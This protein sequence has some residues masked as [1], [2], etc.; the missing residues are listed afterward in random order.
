MKKDIIGSIYQDLKIY[1]CISI[2]LFVISCSKSKDVNKNLP[3]IIYIL[4]DDLGYGELGVYGQ[5]KIETPHIDALA[6]SGMK[7]TEHYAGSAV[8]APSRYMLMKGKHPGNAY[9]RGNDELSE[10]GDIWS[11]EAMYDNPELE[12]QRPIPAETVTIGKLLQSA[13]YKTGAIGKW[14]LGGPCTVGHPNEQGF[15][16]FYGYLCQRQAHTYY[17]THLWKNKQ[18]VYLDNELISPHQTLSEELDPYEWSS[19]EKFQDQPDHSAEL[20]HIEALQFIEQNQ[21]NK[22]FLYLPTPI[23]H[24]PLQAP[25]HWID[26]YVNKFGDEEP[27]PG[28]NYTPVRY[29]NATYAALISYMDEQVGELIEKLKDLD[30]YDNTLIIFTSDNGPTFTG[31]VD[32]EYFDSAAPFKGTYGWGKGYLHE[33]GIRVPMIASWNGKIPEGS[34][35]DHISAQ[36]DVLPTLSEIAGIETP[37]DIDG[38]SFLPTLIG[39]EKEQKQHEFLYWEIPEYG[40]Q[41][42][43]RMGKWK[44][45][46]KNMINNQNI[47]IELFDLEKDIRED[48][49]IADEHPDIVEKIKLIME[50]ERTAPENDLFKIPVLGD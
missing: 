22:F 13:G 10:R 11:F 42:A 37:D 32:P 17:P 28:G 35:S 4:A 29:P 25:E 46:R 5:E 16:F 6:T 48:H 15:D 33:G 44:G 18:R 49:N 12:G 36:W 9:I 38:I 34:I 30:L 23:P 47:E 26:Y 24:V 3:N 27:Y 40:G 7:F 31:G 14:G 8:C 41:Q 50:K 1:L 43:V 21:E 45:I 19:Y 2:L 39:K 20:M